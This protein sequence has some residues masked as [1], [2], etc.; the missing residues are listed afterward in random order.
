MTTKEYK[1]FRIKAKE[2]I[3][4]AEEKFVREL[5][6]PLITESTSEAPQPCWKLYEGRKFDV[7]TEFRWRKIK[8][9]K[10]LT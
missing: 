5:L 9:S 4:K 2:A 3:E 1:E 8:A 6:A 7:C 10:A